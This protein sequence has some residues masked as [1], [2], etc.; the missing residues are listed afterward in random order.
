MPANDDSITAAATAAS[1]AANPIAASPTAP[2]DMLLHRIAAEF[3]TPVYIYDLDRVRERVQQL[4]QA[5]PEA[6]IRYAVKANPSGAVLRAIAQLP[7]TGAEVI[8][9]GEL[10]RAVAAGFSGDT[11]LL[12][13]PA[14]GPALRRLALEHEVALV[15]L[16]SVSQWH[17]WR[18]DLAALPAGSAQP[19]F[20]VRIN[21]QLDP[22]TH[23]HLATG[24]ADS[25]FGMPLADATRVAA[26]A[27]AVGSLAGFHVHAG[28]QIAELSVFSAVLK[29]LTPL[30]ERFPVRILD[31]GG[32]YRVPDFPLSDY[33][34]IVAGFAREHAL[35]LIIEPGRYLV[36]DAGTLL[37]RVLHLKQGALQHVIADAGMADLLRP[38]LYGAAH[39][40][41]LVPAAGEDRKAGTLLTV[42]LD[43]PLCENA[44]RLGRNLTLPALQQGDLLAV[45]LAG[46]YGLTM[47]SNYASSLRPAEVVI[48]QGS[49]RLARRRETVA[50]LLAFEVDEVPVGS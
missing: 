7:G 27:A 38:A 14:Q 15:S 39:P 12:G 47:A 37:T 48:E 13:G 24:A 3:G 34:G 10:A 6:L 44:D 49:Y 30:F 11:I 16:D 31:I 5:L 19:Q 28:S 20:L 32:G 22:Q 45:G 46:A 33:A 50:D 8:T 18:N 23:E 35:Q 41:R 4:R 26:E 2:G 9:A 42:D 25:K 21:P 43:G 36:A 29:V 1:Q 17:D 40:V